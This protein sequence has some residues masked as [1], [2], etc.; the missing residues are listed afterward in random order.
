METKTQNF[1]CQAMPLCGTSSSQR[2]SMFVFVPCQHLLF[3]DLRI[4]W[5]ALPYKC[6][7]ALS[8]EMYVEVNTKGMN[9]CNCRLRKKWGKRPR[10]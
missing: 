1:P 6:V 8:T 2:K 9:G 5:E 4:E 7:A 10:H 3:S